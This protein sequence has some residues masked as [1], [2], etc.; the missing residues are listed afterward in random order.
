MFNRDNDARFPATLSGFSL[1]RFEVTVGRFRRFVEA[2]PASK[3]A[4]GAGRHPLIAGSGWS[5]DWAGHLPADAAA[6]ETAVL[7][8]AGYHTWTNEPGDHEQLPMNCLSWYEAFAFCAWDGGRLATEAE[9][10]YAAAGGDEQR[11]YPWST[12]ASSTT[13]DGSYAVYGCA[14]DGSAPGDCA[15]SAIQVVGSRSPKGD[16]RWGHADL[17][18]NVWE[19]VLDSYTDYPSE[20]DD[21]ANLTIV[22]LRAIRGGGWF[23]DASGLLSSRRY[24]GNPYVRS[25]VGVRCARTP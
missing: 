4:P 24:D 18:G 21:C 11:A 15:S 25:H 5:A 9:W 14:A 17:A 8:S 2:Y 10:N 22:S 16:G 7:C 13:I 23:Y 12:P 19:W 6:L 3:P 20:C 1:D